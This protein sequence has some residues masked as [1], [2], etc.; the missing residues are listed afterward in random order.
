MGNSETSSKRFTK[1]KIV[2]MTRRAQNKQMIPTYRILNFQ[3]A[4]DGRCQGISKT[5]SRKIY[6][7]INS[8]LPYLLDPT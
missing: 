7:H 3:N 2:I 6:I 1:F 8:T 5:I 4:G